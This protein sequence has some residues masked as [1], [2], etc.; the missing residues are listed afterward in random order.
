M[1][2]GSGEFGSSYYGGGFPLFQVTGATAINSFTVVV[3]FTNPPDFSNPET[4][5]PANYVISTV[6]PEELLPTVQVQPDNDPNSV[7][8]ITGLQHYILY[9]V[10]VANLVTDTNAVGVDSEADTA[11]LT[12][13]PAEGEFGF[14][15]KA[16]RPDGINLVFSQPMSVDGSLLDPV[17]YTVTEVS[18]GSA[19]PVVAVSSNYPSDATRVVLSLGSGMRSAVSY[20][21]TIS[22]VRTSDGR[23]VLPSS[24]LVVW[25]QRPLVTKVPFSSFTREVRAREG[26]LEQVAET[27]HLHETLS[28]V[29]EPW[30]GQAFEER[31]DFVENLSVAS[32]NSSEVTYVSTSSSMLFRSQAS[33]R[34]VLDTRPNVS[35]QV[36]ERFELREFL[37]VLPELPNGS[38]DPGI[39]ELFG[40]PQGLV[41]FSPSLVPGGAPNSSIQVDEVNACTTAYD[42]YVFPKPVDP[43]ALFTFSPFG[44]STLNNAS[45]FTNFYRLGEARH[46]LA[47]KED[48]LVSPASDIGATMVLTEVWPPLRAA[49]LNSPGWTLFT[50]AAAPPYNFITADN[51]SPFP[52][53]TTGNTQHFVNPSE[54]LG[55]VE[56]ITQSHGMAS[57]LSETLARTD[58]FDLTP[59]ENVV[60]VNISDSVSLSDSVVTQMGINLSETLTASVGLTVST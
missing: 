35:A 29:A 5:N 10:Q 16:I 18:T 49:L 58:N 25:I 32:S 23:L 38:I 46:N 45:L 13:Y 57:N 28:V 33:Y 21:V 41:F 55:L 54:V 47:I 34:S 17:S 40:S 53:P 43:V 27:F 7:R 48:E 26:M 30:F 1:T 12:G 22:G 51:L 20:R 3:T 11:Q 9:E 31:A 6:G 24:D 19:L 60:Q 14:K 59:G 42:S 36:V 15:A 52:S 44:A 2:F 8:L 39:A 56:A 37:Q 4:T 50:G